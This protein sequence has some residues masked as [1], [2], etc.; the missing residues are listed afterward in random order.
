M[1][2]TEEDGPD[3]PVERAVALADREW[4]AMGIVMTERTALTGDLRRELVG[5]AADGVAPRQ[6]LGDDVRRFAHELAVAAGA[7]RAPY[8]FRRLLL[9]ALAGGVPG[10]LLAFVLVWTWWLVPLHV[11]PGPDPVLNVLLRYVL[12]ALVF[13]GGGLLAV[14]YGMRDSAG[15]G[16]T[17]VRM[18]LLV[19]PAGILAVPVT[20]GFAALTG[21]S[22]SPPVLLV[23]A[24]IV[25][26]ALGGA[27]V[28]ARRWALSPIRG[29]A[30]PPSDPPDGRSPS[31]QIPT[32]PSPTGPSSI[33]PRPTGPSS[34]GPSSTGPSSTG[35]SSTGP[36][37]S[38]PSP[39]VAKPAGP[40]SDPGP[41]RMV[42]G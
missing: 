35:P 20:M 23:E 36:S 26:A 41:A 4:R 21:Y 18:A 40:G 11:L 28:L 22:L 3:D 1:S 39:T 13:V 7:R 29:A 27:T 24:G 38:G 30:Q 14:R 33:G 16:R 17:V 6:L 10:L 5:A 32:D 8:E 25:A 34:T 15:I 2:W 9:T 31:G 19:P 42:L 37:S 12:S